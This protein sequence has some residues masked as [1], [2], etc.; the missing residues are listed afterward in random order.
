[1]SLESLIFFPEDFELQSAIL[2]NEPYKGIIYS[3]VL[4]NSY[5]I[6]LSKI[7]KNYTDESGCYPPQQAASKTCI[8][9]IL[10]LSYGKFT[11]PQLKPRT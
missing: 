9:L 4:L 5:G 7:M 3:G 8:I 10:I 11:K 6:K 2:T 1:M